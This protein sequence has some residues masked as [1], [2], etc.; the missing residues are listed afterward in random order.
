[1]VK[2]R[3]YALGYQ[4]HYDK[5][6][7]STRLIQELKPSLAP[8]PIKEKK[9]QAA[10]KE[11]L[12]VVK[13]KRH[14]VSAIRDFPLVPEKFNPYLSEE[15][16]CVLHTHLT[17]IFDKYAQMEM[18]EIRLLKARALR[19]GFDRQRVAFLA[20]INKD[21]EVL[22]KTKKTHLKTHSRSVRPWGSVIG[23]SVSSLT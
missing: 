23:S 14:S 7:V 15:R 11:D 4:P 2:F 8:E 16:R 6:R 21:C 10:P 17:Q 19:E 12:A 22:V 1:M 3:P 5:H 13:W 18:E 9:A 20:S